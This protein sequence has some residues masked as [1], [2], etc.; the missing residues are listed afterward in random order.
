MTNQ[1]LG[2]PDGLCRLRLQM[3]GKPIVV[4]ERL[5]RKHEATHIV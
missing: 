2:E 3:A 1:D 5:A 4:D